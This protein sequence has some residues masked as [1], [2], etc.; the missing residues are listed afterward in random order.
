MEGLNVLK[1]EERC[2][3]GHSCSSGAP[4]GCYNSECKASATYKVRAIVIVMLE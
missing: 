3:Y 4:G 2:D 1:R